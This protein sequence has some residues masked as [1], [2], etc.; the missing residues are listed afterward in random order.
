MATV[1]LTAGDLLNQDVLISTN[2]HP[3]DRQSASKV[4]TALYRE[5]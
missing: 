4:F 1:E 3:I 2:L 5:R